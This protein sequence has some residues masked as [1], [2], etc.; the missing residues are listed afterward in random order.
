MP[1]PGLPVAP[2]PGTAP[3]APIALGAADSGL[4]ITNFEGEEA[5]LSGG[6]PLAT[7]WE[8]VDAAR[9]VWVARLAESDVPRSGSAGASATTKSTFFLSSFSSA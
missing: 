7:A 1:A 3:G 2:I 4:T 5:W 9:N 8:L 6:V